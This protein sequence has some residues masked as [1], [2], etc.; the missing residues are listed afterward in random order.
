MSR[1]N[2]DRRIRNRQAKNF[3]I[4]EAHNFQEVDPAAAEKLKAISAD[5]P[6]GLHTEVRTTPAAEW[7]K[8]GEIDPHAGQYDGERAALAL[9]HLTDDSLANGIFMNYDKPFD[10]HATIAR[11]P[12]YH[13]PIAWMTAG[14]DR[15]RWLSRSLEKELAR[16]AELEKRI[17]ELEAAQPAAIPQIN[18]PMPTGYALVPKL[19]EGRAG[20]THEMMT[21]FYK[22]FEANQQRGDFERL[23]AGY[24]ALIGAAPHPSPDEAALMAIEKSIDQR[25]EF[26]PEVKSEPSTEILGN[27]EIVHDS[28][29]LVTFHRDGRIEL[30]DNAKPSEAATIMFDLIREMWAEPKQPVKPID[31]S[32]IKGAVPTHR[33]K[34]CGAQWRKYQDPKNEWNWTLCS[35]QAAL[36][37]DNT[38]MGDQIEE[39]K[40]GS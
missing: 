31:V 4:D 40:D 30:S 28:K 32:L 39:L 9:G 5:M 29:P 2:K 15:I 10:I 23:N 19:H 38:A 18:L 26:T 20:L 17:A 25:Y 6:E 1:K 3:M 13:P 35:Q 16:N 12:G 22:A 37:C 7:R 33:C 8:K 34:V 14:K 11:T 27:F 21:A 36:C 24:N